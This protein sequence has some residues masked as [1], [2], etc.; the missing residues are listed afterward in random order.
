MS[1]TMP[2]IFILFLLGLPQA[3]IH[4]EERYQL[5][6]D[7][8]TGEP[9]KFENVMDDLA[10]VKVVYLGEVHRLQRHH[11]LHREIVQ[12]LGKRGKKVL[13]GIEQ[14]EYTFQETLNRFNRGEIEFDRLADETR[15]WERWKN[16]RDYR[17]I[18]NT[19]RNTGGAI[20]AIN[21]PAEIIRAVGKKG[22]DNITT[23]ER[24]ALPSSLNFNDPLYERWLNQQLLV[25]A[26]FMPEAL[27]TIFQAQVARDETMAYRLH[28]AWRRLPDPE[29]WIAVIL[30]GGGHCAYGLGTPSRFRYYEPRMKDRIVMAGESGDSV[31]TETEKSMMRDIRITHEDLRFLQRPLADYLHVVELGDRK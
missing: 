16:F 17:D 22:I 29:N 6:I 31:L 18:I 3:P 30:C 21:A 27:H 5:W 12:S 28:L 20:A 23:E 4:A 19:A 15:W 8:Y 25:H 9:I 24:A 7:L 11:D 2:C 14:M 1:R 13:L 26:Q 10:D